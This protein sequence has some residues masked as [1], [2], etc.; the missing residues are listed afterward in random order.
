M[1]RV[2]GDREYIGASKKPYELYGASL[3]I[4]TP[5][6]PNYYENDKLEGNLESSQLVGT[7]NRSL[8]LVALE[9]GSNGL[10]GA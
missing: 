8:E 3:I 7:S 2:L 6:V 5:L 1:E 4:L 10:E 9:T